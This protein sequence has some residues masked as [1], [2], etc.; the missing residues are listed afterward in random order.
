MEAG[1]SNKGIYRCLCVMNGFSK[2]KLRVAPE[3]AIQKEKLLKT[4]GQMATIHL[5]KF[6]THVMRNQKHF[7]L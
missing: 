3:T 6:S 1:E 5:L 7:Y 2:V 4:L